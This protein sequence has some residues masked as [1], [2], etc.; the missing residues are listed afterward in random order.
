MT[1]V[2]YDSVNN[3]TIIDTSGK[4]PEEKVR[5]DY[6][7][8]LQRFEVAPDEVFVNG[9]V[10]KKADI[11]NEVVQEKKAKKDAARN[12]ITAK[13]QLSDNDIEDLRTLILGG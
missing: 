3:H 8:P 1:I 6:P 11:D 7:H 12:R 10:R 4:K 5:G 13:L 9:V 2:Y